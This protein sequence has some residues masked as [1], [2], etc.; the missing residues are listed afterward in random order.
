M[1]P[2]EEATL[3]LTV[4]APQ[5]EPDEDARTFSYTRGEQAGD[6]ADEAA[7]A[8]DLETETNTWTFRVDSG[9]VLDPS[10]TLASRDLADGDVVTLT[11][12]GRGV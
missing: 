6:A 11:D 5:G 1:S 10:T 4:R 3:E 7:E 2:A 8:Y 12:F 9:D